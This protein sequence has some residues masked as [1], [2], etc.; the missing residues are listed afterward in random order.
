MQQ[1]VQLLGKQSVVVFQVVAKEWEGFDRRA[2]TDHHLGASLRKQVER[3]ELLE[4]AH[5]I[6]RAQDGHR[7]GQTNA[8]RSSSRC[9]QDHRRRKVE[10]LAFVVFANSENIQTDL[11]RLLDALEQLAHAV[12]G[13]C[14]QA[15]V[16]EPGGKAINSYFHLCLPCIRG[17]RILSDGLELDFDRGSVA[18]EDAASLE[19]HIPVQTEVL[20]IELCHR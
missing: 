5:L 7:A 14:C 20:P 15:G 17:R 13:A 11:V 4:Q 19:R 1:E 16:V 6:R 18:H 8:S 12:Y 3:G 10:E 2:A 9:S